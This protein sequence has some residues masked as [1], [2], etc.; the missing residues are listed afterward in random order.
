MTPAAI[1]ALELRQ[2]LAKSSTSKLDAFAA[3]TGPDGRLRHEFA[4][5]GAHTGRWSS[6]G[7]QIHN[8]PRGVLKE[9]TYDA[10]VEAI[11]AGRDVLPF[12]NPLDV[13]SSTLRGAFRAP[14]GYHFVVSDLAQIEVRVLAWL[15][16]CPRLRGAFEAGTCPYRDFYARWQGVPIEDVTPAQRDISKPAVLGSGYGLGPGERRTDKNGDEYK[17]GLWGYAENM[18]VTLTQAAAVDMTYSYRSL[19]Y[20]VPKFWGD[21]DAAVQHTIAD[22]GTKTVGQVRIGCYRGKHLWLELPSGRRLRYLDPQH[23]DRDV[24]YRGLLGGKAIRKKLYGGLLTE[25]LCQAIARDVLAEGMLAADAAGFSIVGHV[26]DEVICLERVDDAA[27]TSARLGALLSTR[28]TWAPG[29]TLGAD[30][31]SSVVYK[32]G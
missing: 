30:G 26:H 29:L 23:D 28:P 21:L 14:E 16:N 10:A 12:G 1:R 9:D 25:N 19:Y 20:H 11:R 24:T 17:S 6:R 7:V 8:L 4:Y 18:G 27:H 32:K 5:Y 31:Y 13:V 15:S 22:G 2:R 3:R